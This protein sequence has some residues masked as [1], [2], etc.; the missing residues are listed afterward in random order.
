MTK[1][2]EQTG[3]HTTIIFRHDTDPETLKKMISELQDLRLEGKSVCITGNKY[4]D[5]QKGEPE[6]IKTCLLEF[7]EEEGNLKKMENL[8][9]KF[10]YRRY[11]EVQYEFT[12]HVSIGNKDPNGRKYQEYV[13]NQKTLDENGDIYVLGELYLKNLDTKE[14]ITL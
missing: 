2:G 12:F 3:L 4:L 13:D 14:V 10:T 1:S 5:G 11:L 7:S 8:C 6:M 9:K